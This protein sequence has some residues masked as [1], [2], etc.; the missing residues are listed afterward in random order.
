MTQQNNQS[1]ASSKASSTNTTA[2]SN[3][4]SLEEKADKVVEILDSNKPE[5]QKEDEVW[6]IL[7]NV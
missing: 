6:E 1:D 3:N 5:Q 7:K 4:L 2:N